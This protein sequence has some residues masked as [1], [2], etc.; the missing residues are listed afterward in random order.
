MADGRTA[1][2]TLMNQ[3]IISGGKQTTALNTRTLVSDLITSLPNITDDKDKANGY[4]GVNSSGIANTTTLKASSANGYFLRDDGTWQPA[5]VAGGYTTGSVMFAGPSGN[6]IQDNA[7]FFWNDAAALLY[8]NG[9][10]GAFTQTKLQI[11]DSFNGFSQF[12]YMNTS[13]GSSA[14]SDLVTNADTAT[15]STNYGNFGTNSSTYSLSSYTITGPID[16]YAVA[17]GGNMVIG[18]ETAKDIVFFT[19]NTLAANEVGR[20][21]NGSGLQVNNRTAFGQPFSYQTFANLTNYFGGVIQ[22]GTTTSGYAIYADHIIQSG[23]TSSAAY[24]SSTANTAASGSSYTVANLSHYIA[25]EGTFGSNS[26]VTSQYGFRVGALSSGVNNYAF[27]STTSAAT[28]R[29]N[30]YMAGTAQNYFNGSLGIGI[31]VPTSKLHVVAPTTATSAL[32]QGVLISSFSTAVADGDVLV[33][34]DLVMG[35]PSTSTQIKYLNGP[36]GGSGYVDATY[37]SVALTGGTGSGAV[38]TIVV[39]GGV[40]VQVTPTSPGTGYTVA[41]SLTTANTN[42]GGSGSGFTITVAALGFVS[43]PISF[44][45]STADAVFNGLTVGR[46]SGAVSTN[47]ALGASALVANTV[48]AQ[49]VAVGANALLSN[50]TGSLSVA[51]GYQALRAAI[52]ATGNTAIG[53]N[54]LIAATGISN[55]A[56][57][58]TAGGSVTTGTT[59]T[60]LGATSGNNGSQLVSATNSTAVGFGTFTSASNSVILG[61]ASVT[62]VTFGQTKLGFTLPAAAT[63][64]VFASGSTF[65]TVGNFAVTNTYTNITNATFPAGTGTLPYIGSTNTWSAA[66]TFSATITTNHIIGSSIAPTFAAG[67]G[68]GTSPTI[69]LTGTDLGGFINVTTG[70]T[71]TASGVVVTVTF[72]AAYGA[73]PRCVL[74]TPANA[75]AAALTGANQV[76]VSQAGITTTTFALT[77]GSVAPGASTA[78]Q[79]YYT[80]IQ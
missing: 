79:F 33:G 56:L 3:V 59:N 49:N 12:S 69:T 9:N 60:F 18:T 40:V 65:T 46:G 66:Q 37:T 30:V 23:V 78:Y 32:A 35:F 77:A 48:G 61:N 28:N 73:A 72:N 74:I 10:T 64:I 42:L 52:Y 21:L 34:V 38:A 55:T 27:Y 26:T 47:A 29:W 67:T 15:N 54:S 43:K 19:G 57:G 63:S 39:L 14:S 31:T 53:Q 45:S 71:P 51:V 17:N 22:P 6:I 41:D 11:F 62:L 1:L 76:F 80:V 2:T 25:G 58:N 4:V 7:K 16:T 44:R 20:F 50:T 68:A 13:P 36:T 70:T 5:A 24:F 8:I 75:A